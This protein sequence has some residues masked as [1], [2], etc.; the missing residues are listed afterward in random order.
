VS[1]ARRAIE[2]RFPHGGPVVVLGELLPHELLQA[3]QATGDERT[4]VGGGYAVTR[5]A[6]RRS[7]RRVDGKEVGYTDLVGEAWR[8]FFPRTRHTHQLSRAWSTLHHPGGLEIDAFRASMQV[9]VDG[10]HER[11]TATLPGGRKVVMV[12]G[13]EQ[14][15][16]EILRAVGGR[17]RSESAQSWAMTM[18]GCRRALRQ[19]EDRPLTAEDLGG[20]KWDAV[21]G[22]KE[23]LLLGI[24]W[25]EIHMGHEEVVLG[26]ASLAGGTP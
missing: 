12:E 26:E 14:T 24:L 13:D 6:L 15:V 8:T 18:D 23:T 5:E 16:E 10:E 25:G 7:I 1:R 9:D 11:W 4:Q 22:V 2:A 17:S 21:F 3:M 20:R 19:V